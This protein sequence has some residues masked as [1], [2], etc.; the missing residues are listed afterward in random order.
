MYTYTQQKQQKWNVQDGKRAGEPVKCF[1]QLSHFL[2]QQKTLLFDQNKSFQPFDLNLGFQFSPSKRQKP[3]FSSIFLFLLN[4]QSPKVQGTI[5]TSF[6]AHLPSSFSAFHSINGERRRRSGTD[7]GS[8]GEKLVW[9]NLGQWDGKWGS[10]PLASWS[11][12]LLF[13]HCQLMGSMQASFFRFCF[14]VCKSI[15]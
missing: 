10:C 1:I 4:S 12:K 9:L 5:V 8:F 13:F 2:P 11:K 14:R 6:P 15:Y 3:S 7:G